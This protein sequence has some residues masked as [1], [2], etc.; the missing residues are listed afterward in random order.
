MAITYGT[1][2]V[3]G[4]TSSGILGLGTSSKREKPWLVNECLSVLL[5]FINH[6]FG[7]RAI[8]NERENGISETIKR[9]RKK[10]KLTL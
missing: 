7:K 1:Y 2:L 6:K 8:T 4:N 5:Q 9:I 10:T 3:S